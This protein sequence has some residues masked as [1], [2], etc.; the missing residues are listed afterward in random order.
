MKKYLSVFSLIARNSI[1]RIVGLLLLLVVADCV[2]AWYW[3]SVL[4]YD[5][6]NLFRN[7]NGG[8]GIALTVIFAAIAVVQLRRGDMYSGAQGYTMQR[9]AISEKAVA[10]LQIL[11]HILCW[12]ILWGV[13]V[14]TIFLICN[15]YYRFGLGNPLTRQYIFHLFYISPLLHSLL[16]MEETL[17]WITNAAMV[18]GISVATTYGMIRRRGKKPAGEVIPVIFLVIVIFRRELGSF[19][20]NVMTAL[21]Y[22][23]LTVICGYR[24]FFRKKEV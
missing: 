10:L 11:Y 16:P 24:I 20:F 17:V 6:S 14:L 7:G 15:A 3:I 21:G 22:L 19:F 2:L 4:G 12:L 13:Q 5:L 1:Y 9:L 18:V 8:F 23:A